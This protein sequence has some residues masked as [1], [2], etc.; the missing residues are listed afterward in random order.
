MSKKLLAI[1][2]E[3]GAIKKDS[4]NPFFKSKYFDINTLLEQVKPI[5]H[6]HDVVV[7]QPLSNIDGKLA[8]K[9][10]LIDCETGE[11]IDE[12]I[13]PLPEMPDPQ[14]S[15]SAITYFRRY[16]LQSLLALEAEDDDAN[17]A[18]TKPKTAPQATIT[19]KVKALPENI[20]NAVNNAMTEEEL[21]VIWKA[22]E[23]LGAEF[24]K[25]VNAQKEFIKSIKQEEN[26]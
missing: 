3:I 15:G 19:P 6:K 1:Q 14:K 20:V 13:C 18:S 4:E 11:V 16:A 21:K 8:L 5:L 22:N 24:N 2:K 23:K 10:K 25:I 12:D 26:K 7:T 9:T 17:L